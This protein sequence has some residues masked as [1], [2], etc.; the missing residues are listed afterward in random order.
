MEDS[1]SLLI[2]LD[3]VRAERSAFDEQ[4][5]LVTS[6]EDEK[7]A[8]RIIR[9]R[10]LGRK[11][12]LATLIRGIG[13]LESSD[14]LQAGKALNEHKSLVE[15]QIAAAEVRFEDK[16]L[17][18]RVSAERV[19][20]TLPGRTKW[21]GSVHPLLETVFRALEI[22]SSMG[23]S[24]RFGEEIGTEETM[25]DFL[26]FPK[27]HP[28]R[29]EQDTYYLPGGSILRSQTSSAQVSLMRNQHPPIR[30]VVPG[31]CFRNEE[32]SSRS[33]NIF[34]QIEGLYVDRDVRLGDLLSTLEVFYASFL[35]QSTKLRFRSSYFPFV[36]PGIEVDISCFLCR[37]QGCF[38]CK[39]SGWLEVAGAGMVHPNVLRNGRVDPDLYSGFAWGFGLER[40]VLLLYGIPDIR[41][42]VEN[43]PSFL[44]QFPWR[45]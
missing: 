14:R 16:K 22:L 21:V 8:L 3:A 11:S 2:V 37:G 23:F 39:R 24:V 28:A 40:L 13:Q 41:L 30:F 44:R 32:I 10:F 35:G 7:E 26:N 6:S 43:H 17:K 4:I 33:L 42:L 9:I 34:H 15:E 36:E 20:V 12:P 19:D 29:L 1:F 5:S 38:T 18:E 31:K 25:F 45:G 27:N